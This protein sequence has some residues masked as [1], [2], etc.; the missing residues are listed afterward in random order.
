LHPRRSRETP[1]SVIPSCPFAK[2]V[3]RNLRAKGP[4]RGSSGRIFFSK[5]TSQEQ[6]YAAAFRQDMQH[7]QPH[8][9]Q[10]YGNNL[11]SPCSGIFHN[12]KFR[13]QV[14]SV[15]APSSSNSDKLKIATVVQQIMTEIS[16]ALRKRQN[17]GH[18]KN[19]T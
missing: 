19:V 6:S 10:T 18:Y 9:P 2:G 11:R 1:S 3:L 7:Q 8:A 15:Q 13:E 14:L 4:P 5:F 16:E 17:N 12:R